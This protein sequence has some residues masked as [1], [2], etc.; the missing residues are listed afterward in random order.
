MNQ[1][2]LKL[3]SE[4]I[5]DKYVKIASNSLNAKEKLFK[6]LLSQRQL[7]EEGF[8]DLTIEY[9]LNIFATMD[10]NNFSNKVGVGERESRIF[11]ALVQK[12][13]YYMGHG[14]GRSGDLIASQPKAAGSSLIAKLTKHLAKDALKLSNYQINELLLVPVATGMAISLC[15]LALKSLKPQAKYV[16]WPRIDQ[17]TCLKCIQTANLIPIVIDSVIQDHVVTTNLDMLIQKVNE[18]GPDNIVCVLSTT[19]CF[20][21]RIPDNIGEIAKICKQFSIYHVVNNA[22]GLQCNKIANSINLGLA[23]GT[24]NLIVSS[25]DKNFMVPVGGAL[26]YGNDKKLIKQ[27]SELYPGRASAAPILD[28]FITFLSMGKS[29][30]LQLQKERV[31]NYA[32]FKEKL[33]I[34]TQKISEQILNTPKNSISIGISLQNLKID[35]NNQEE[36]NQITKLGAILYSK[37]V[38]GSR[39]IT[40]KKNKVVCGIEFKNYGS[41]CDNYF[42]PY[43]T[44][45]CAIGLTKQEI[46]TFVQEFEKAYTQNT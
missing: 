35:Q 22:Y 32:Y 19:S 26:I 16:L 3:C 2:N 5:D 21:P 10:T 41:H 29:G 46:D 7:P 24:V 13:N 23:Q 37:K 40:N 12:R 9:L 18:I 14:I 28:L 15:L 34:M 4:I 6:L 44:V 42:T 45:A 8:D 31:E 39:V 43:I 25:T 36:K 17:K 33:Q 30:Y 1:Q 11:S 20:A 27:I 38:M